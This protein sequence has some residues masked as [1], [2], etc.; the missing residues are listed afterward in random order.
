MPAQVKKEKKIKTVKKAKGKCKDIKKYP[1]GTV[2][3]KN[4]KEVIHSE[5]QVQLERCDENVMLEEQYRIALER[6][7]WF[8]KWLI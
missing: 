4:Y 8:H 2:H 3:V 6:K 1:S 5:L 7:K